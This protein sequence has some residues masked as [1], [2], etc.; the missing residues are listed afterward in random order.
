MANSSIILSQLSLFFSFGFSIFLDMRLVILYYNR[1]EME[2]KE[3]KRNYLFVIGGPGGSGSSTIAKMFAEYF[4]MER[5]YG[6]DL[7]RRLV[8]EKGY[9]NFEDFYNSSNEEQLLE[10]DREIDSLLLKRAKEGNVII[11]SKIFSGIATKENIVCTAKIW[12]TASLW[13]R[14]KRAVG[15]RGNLNFFTKFCLMISS[16]RDLKKRWNLD[17]RRYLKL[18][19]VEY[20]SPMLYNDIVIDST[21]L[22]EKQTFDL[23]L[24]KLKDGGFI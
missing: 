1:V 8:K 5:V 22:D 11:E 18:Y 23:I 14:A 12:L 17:R 24:E 9:E 10:F 15:K 2:N 3:L 7:M 6:G 19:S 20:E 4:G 21:K 16:M 13:T